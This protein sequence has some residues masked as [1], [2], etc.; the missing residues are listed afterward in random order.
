MPGRRYSEFVD[1]LTPVQAQCANAPQEVLQ[2]LPWKE[3]RLVLAHEPQAAR[4][5]SAKRD[6]VIQKLEAQD[7]GQRGRGRRLSD[8]GARARFYREV[9][10]AHLS[11]IVRVDLKS[12]LSATRLTLSGASGCSSPRSRLARCTIACPRAS[13]RTQRSASWR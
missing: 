13:M 6:A 9:Y 2:E 3:L 11:R 8:G 7:T 5:A 1:L 12:E 10:E 4:E